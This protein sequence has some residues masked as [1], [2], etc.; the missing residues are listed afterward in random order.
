MTTLIDNNPQG[1]ADAALSWYWGRVYADLMNTT[2]YRSWYIDDRAD[3]KNFWLLLAIAQPDLWMK[4]R[5]KTA[6]PQGHLVKAKRFM[7]SAEYSEKILELMEKEEEE[8]E[9]TDEPVFPCPNCEYCKAPKTWDTTRYIKGN[10]FLNK[11][12]CLECFE[13]HHES[14]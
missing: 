3:P 1:A 9:E 8:A 6:I 4:L 7:K 2:D 10:T 12:A 11:D 13:K 5:G 14:D